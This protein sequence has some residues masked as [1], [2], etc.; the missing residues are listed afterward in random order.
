[1]KSFYFQFLTGARVIIA[2]YDMQKGNQALKQL[3]DE[4]D[5]H[6][7]NIRLMKCDLR[8]FESVRQF[9]QLYNDEEKKLDVLICNAGI[10]WAPD[11]ITK[12]GINTVMQV[13][14]LSHFLLTNLFLDK[15]KEC[16]P[17]RIVFVASGSHRSK[18]IFGMIAYLKKNI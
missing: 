10:V 6:E 15:L 1:M 12:D 4:T 18:S 9:V 5:C 13:N 7:K 14:Y 17:S 11:L 3:R 2:D 8:S 16:R